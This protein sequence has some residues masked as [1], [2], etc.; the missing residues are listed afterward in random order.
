MTDDPGGN[1][2]SCARCGRDRSNDPSLD[3]VPRP[4]CPDCG[5]TAVHYTRHVSE[6]VVSQSITVSYEMTPADQSRGWQLR[7]RTLHAELAELTVPWHGGVTTR[8]I[9]EAERTLLSFF[10]DAYH[11]KDALI[12]GSALTAPVVESA[13]TAS[14]E[15]SLLADLANLDKHHR[16]D[17]KKYP[18]RSGHVPVVKTRSAVSDGDG[19]RVR[20]TIEHKGQRLDALEIAK[21]AMKA[22]ETFLQSQAML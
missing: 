16:L 17:T 7:W 22:W 3:A 2:A 14:S 12:K 10:V 20:T 13:L 1:G 5:E 6:I 9:E 21:A 8:K 4:P 11:L 19:W 18:P 15:L